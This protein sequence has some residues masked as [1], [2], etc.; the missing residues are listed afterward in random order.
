MKLPTLEQLL[1][2]PRGELLRLEKDVAEALKQTSIKARND[3][4]EQIMKIAAEAGFGLTDLF[5]AV[6]AKAPKA[7]AERTIRY[8]DGENVWGGRGKRPQWVNEFVEAG[9]NLEDI[10]I[11]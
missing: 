11:A 4:K 7:K 9:G 2:A 10:K 3:A 1:E 6:V 5:G 8:R